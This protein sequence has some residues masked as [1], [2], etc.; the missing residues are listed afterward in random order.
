MRHLL[1]AFAASILLAFG[2]LAAFDRG[3]AGSDPPLVSDLSTNSAA[4]PRHS[5]VVRSA[6][7]F[8]EILPPDR[9]EGDNS[10]LIVFG[11]ADVI[12]SLCGAQNL[13]CTWFQQGVPI[14][15]APNPCLLANRD[16]YAAILCHEL[17][18]ANGWPKTHGD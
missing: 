13:A 10:A 14:M 8:G 3:P 12:A 4:P 17:G 5:G 7:S 2:L 16:L 1:V 18:H 11:H 15:A 9:F 6:D